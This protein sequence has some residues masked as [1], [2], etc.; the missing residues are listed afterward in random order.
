MRSLNVWPYLP[1]PNPC[2]G[3]V[4]ITKQLCQ[5]LG[6]APALLVRVARRRVCAP[7]RARLGASWT[8]GGKAVTG[9]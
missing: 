6:D 3:R 1:G 4:N 7:S 9:L 2:L 5:L 8:F